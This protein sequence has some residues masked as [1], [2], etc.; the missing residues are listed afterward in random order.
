MANILKIKRSSVQ[1]KIPAVADLQLGELAINTYDGKLF[2]KKDVGGVEAIVDVSAGM[3]A[4]GVL[5]LIKTVDGA[6]SGLD[7]DL[8]DGLASSSAN[9]ASTI[10]ARDASGNFS[11]GTITA[12]LSGNASTATTLQTARTINGV[13]F[14]GSANITIADSTKLPLAG[15]TMTGAISFATGQPWPTFN[16][17]TT[18]SAANISNTGSVTLATATESNSVYITAPTYTTDK[19]VKL[20]NFDWYGNVFSIGNIRS[21]DTAS[22]GFGV[23]YTTGGVQTEIARFGTTGSFNTIGAITQNGSQV[24]HAGNYNSYSPTLTGGGASGTWGIGITG[25]AA[26]V[27]NGLYSTGSY[28]DPAWITSINYSKLTGTIPTWNQSTTGSAA[29]WTT[30]RTLS[31]TGD[32]TGSGSVDGSANVATALTLA[33]S[34]VTAGTYTKI[35]VDAKGRATSGTTLTSA[36]IPALDASKI[37]TGVF[38]PAR[39]PSYVDDVLEYANL[40]G[41]PT[42]GE[43]GKIYVA[44]D[45]N[46]TYRWSGTVYV[47]ITS[48]AVDS[49][50]GKTGVVTLVKGDV[51]LGNVDNTADTSKN[52]LSATKL[53]TARTISLTGDVTGSVSFDGSGNAAIVT[54]I[55]ADSVALGTD[56]TGNYVAS[57]AT[58]APL[59]GGATGS[60]GGALTLSLASGYGDTQNPY[61]SKT[62]NTFLAA[63]NGTAGAP[64][65]RA[66]VAADIPTLNQNTTGT[67]ANVSGTVGIANGGTGST[68]AAGALTNLGATTVGSSFFTLANPSA[69]TFPRVNADNTISMLDAATFRSAIGAGTSS[70]TGTVTSVSGTGTVSGLTLSGSVTT[71]GSLTLGGTL[72]LTSGQVTTALG[73]T[74]YNSSNPS[75]YITGINSSM[76]TTALGYTPYN[77]TNP[78]GYTTNTGTVTS[79]G[80]TGSVAGISLS[81]SVTTSGNL[82]LSGTLSASIDNIT[83]EHR[84]F[85][86]MG[87]NHGT[88]TSFDSQGAASTVNFGWRYVQGNTNAPNVGNTGNGQYYGLFVGL[89]NDYAYNTYGMQI[90]IPRA[91][92]T[93]YISL[94]FQEGGAFGAWQKI[95][96]GYADSAGN[97]DTLDGQHGSYYQPSSTAIT[98]SNIGSQSVNYATSA[99]SASTVSNITR[100]DSGSTDLNTL[101]TSGFYRVNGSNAN[102][103]SSWGQLLVV[104]GGSDTI[105]QLY[106]DYATGN[107]ISRAGNP[108]NVGGSG[109]WS[110]WKTN[111]NSGNY[112][113]YAPTL[114]GT[115]ASGTWGINVTGYAE[116]LS[117]APAYTN[118][119]DGWWRSA[120]QAGWYNSDYAVGIYATEAG[121][122]RT[123]NGANF[124]AAG[125]LTANSDERLKEN[126]RSLPVDFV[127]QLASVKCGIYDRIDTEFAKTQVGVSAQSL[128]GVMPNA[129]IEDSEGILS[130]AYGNAALVSAVELAKDNVELRARIGRLESIISTLLNKELT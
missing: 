45:T 121:N 98:T 55:A 90:A 128:Q 80:G 52:V 107:T 112:N 19:P 23:Y 130:V 110:A 49:V 81:G 93:P 114:T 67:A 95:S 26:T 43:T 79:V 27:T 20:L 68:T 88:R 125:N 31:F 103:P 124:I 57:V 41:F 40:A 44:L 101:T 116:Y 113:S 21:A 50:S 8:L 11:A 37:T 123:Y 76:V 60:E 62:A 48:G 14:N 96:A 32:A 46:K 30:A 120:G 5:Q 102:S 58:T 25:N 64:T 66:I 94:R 12:A 87:D 36:D 35:T 6:G 75:G 83:D 127:E 82:S 63:P 78:N 7:A 73:Y 97:A 17:N 34:G 24:L 118:G 9:T 59:S 91:S 53:T 61:A 126:W 77:S 117:G 3:D 56:T 42:T 129:I 89:G 100:G 18:G 69:I 2:L 4:N 122:V 99:G 115:G 71:S 85:N 109:S 16:Q 22:S 70:T 84:L 74:P 15:G 28:A 92:T 72:T 51:G 108:S 13:S 10:V 29:K 105:G 38:D 54:T 119:T 86:N 106:F 111:L 47:Y 1:G 65:F 104:Y 33:N 39:L